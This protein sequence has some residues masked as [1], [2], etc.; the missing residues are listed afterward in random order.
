MTGLATWRGLHRYSIVV[1]FHTVSSGRRVGLDG[2]S[3]GTSRILSPM[4]HIAFIVRSRVTSD[5]LTSHSIV[6]LIVL[7]ME[8][9]SQGFY[10]SCQP[11]NSFPLLVVCRYDRLTSYSAPT[12]HREWHPAKG[13]ISN[14]TE[15]CDEHGTRPHA[16]PGMLIRPDEETEWPSPHFC[17]FQANH[18]GHDFAGVRLS[19]E[20]RA[21]WRLWRCAQNDFSLRDA[22]TAIIGLGSQAPCHVIWEQLNLGGTYCRR[23]V[24]INGVELLTL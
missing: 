3:Q 23:I 24:V 2:R 11:R 7:W 17:L 13:M 6:R 18:G 20:W 1:R 14:P 15:P 10:R 21:S 12:A 4:P 5:S 16:H 8:C 9:D 19:R 22:A